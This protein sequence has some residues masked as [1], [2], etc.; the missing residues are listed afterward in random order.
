MEDQ[1]RKRIAQ[2][3]STYKSHARQ[4]GVLACLA[5][6]V[7]LGVTKGLSK[8]GVTMSVPTQVLDCH[9]TGNGAHTHNED[10]YDENGTLVCPLPEKSLHEHTADCYEEHRELICGLDEDESHTHTDDCYLITQELVCGLEEVTEEHVHGPGCFRTVLVD[11]GT[12][13]ETATADGGVVQQAS[14]EDTLAETMPAQEFTGTLKRYDENKREQT[15]LVAQVKAPE[16]TLPAGTTMVVDHLKQ[17]DA[18]VTKTLVEAA[19]NRETL[20]IQ[21]VKQM[22][23]IEITFK[24]ADGQKVQPTGKLEVKL[25]TSLVREAEQPT[26]V[27]IVDLQDPEDYTL[28]PEDGVAEAIDEHDGAQLMK[29]V[30]LV[31]QDENDTSTGNED[32]LWFEADWFAKACPFVIVETEEAE[33]KNEPVEP[34][35][36]ATAE[37]QADEPAEPADEPAEPAQEEPEQELVT[38]E[39]PAQA[40]SHRFLNADKTPL[41]SVAVDAPEG[42]LPA[43]T[44]M[45][46]E[47]VKPSEVQSIVEDAVAEKAEAENATAKEVQAIQAVDITFYD[48]DGEKIEPAEKITVTLSS[49]RI[50]KNAEEQNESLIVHVDDEGKGT[51]VDSLG[52]DELQERDRADETDELVFDADQFSIYAIAYTVDFHYDVDGETY[53]FSITGGDTLSLRELLTALNVVEAGEAEAFVSQV[54]Q[55]EFSNPDLMAVVK[56]DEDTTSGA[57]KAAHELEP[58]YSTTLTED[59]IAELDAKPLYAGDW[60]LVTLKAFDTEESLTITLANGEVFTIKVTDARDPLGLDGR[61]YALIGQAGGNYHALMPSNNGQALN[62]TSFTE[63]T[64]DSSATYAPENS[65]AWKFEYVST[66]D[67]GNNYYRV[68]SGGK[69]LSINGNALAMADA[70]GDG[71]ETDATLIKITRA[72]DGTYTLGNRSGSALVCQGN[73]FNLGDASAAGAK[74]T[75]ALPEDN[76]DASSASHKA[77]LTSASKLQPGQQV[78]IYQRVLQEDHTYNY[79]ALSVDDAGTNAVA[80]KVWPSSD[81]VYWKGDKNLLWTFTEATDEH[82]TPTGY[83]YFENVNKPGVY[84]AAKA[85]G[86]LVQNLADKYQGNKDNVGV[87][88]P[89]RK[90]EQ[91]TSRIANWDYDRSFSSGITLTEAGGAA[92]I[93]SVAL[94]DSQDFYFAVRDPLVQT[95]LTEVDTVDSASKGINITMFDFS[96]DEGG[97]GGARLR[98]MTDVMG[99]PQWAAGV[100]TPGMMS[101]TLTDDNGNFDPTGYPTSAAWSATGTAYWNGYPYQTTFTGGNQSLKNVF[102]PPT[103]AGYNYSSTA[104]NNVNHLFLQDVYDSTGYFR[105]S[106]FENYARLNSDG[107][108]S[109]YEQIGVP[110]TAG[111]DD[112][113]RYYKKRGNFMPYNDLTTNPRS[114]GNITRPED[115]TE[116]DPADPRKYEDLYQ[117]EE[118]RDY[119]FG[120]IMDAKFQQYPGGLND[121]GDPTRYEFNGDDDLWIYI[122]GV[123]VLD[124]GGV[125]DAFAGYIDF[126]TGKVQVYGG[127]T[128]TIKEQFRKAGKFPDGTNWDNNKVD[129]YF[130]GDTFKDYSTHDFKMFYMERGA[131]ASNL[132][133]QFNLMTVTEDHFRVTKEVPTT[134][135]GRTVQQDYADAAFYYTAYKVADNGN[136]TVCTKTEYGSGGTNQ[137]YYDDKDHTPVVW[138]SENIFEVKPGYTA[139]FPVAN[140]SVK[141]RVEEV[142]PEN[143]SAMLDNFKIE[144]SDPEDGQAE[145][146]DVR[147]KTRT[148]KARGEVVYKNHPNDNLVNEL[149]ITKQLRGDMI[150][151]NGGH[152]I[153]SSETGSPYFEYKIY[154]ENRSGELVP[155]SLGE[156]YLIDKD[157]YFVY[158]VAGD[159]LRHRATLEKD[160]GNDG[161]YTYSYNFDVLDEVQ[162]PNGVTASR[163]TTKNPIL[164]EHTSENGSISDI[165]DGD[166]VYVVGLMEGTDFLVFERLDRSI[167]AKD[168]TGDETHYILEGTE[169]TDAYTRNPETNRPE[170]L[171]GTLYDPASEGKVAFSC[172]HEDETA[173]RGTII[174]SKDAKVLVK[175]KTKQGKG[176]I[177]VEKKWLDAEGNNLADHPT[178]I[179]YTVYQFKHVH[180]WGPWTVEKEATETEPGLE[181]QVCQHDSSHRNTRVIA[182][183]PHE[184]EWVKTVHA[185]T[186]DVGGYVEWHCTKDSTHDYIE[187]T[188]E[189]LGH[190]F[191]SEVTQEPTCSTK[192][193]R[194]YTCTRCAHTYTEEIPTTPHTWVDGD[195][196]EEPSASNNYMGKRKRTC[197]VCGKEEIVEFEGDGELYP[198]TNIK[199]TDYV[200][201]Y[202][203]NMGDNDT[204]HIEPGGIFKYGDSYWVIVKSP[205][206]DPNKSQLKDG[207]GGEL[208]DWGCT[209]QLSGTVYTPETFASGSHYHYDPYNPSSCKRDDMKEGDLFK[210]DDGKFYLYKNRY[211]GW[212]VSPEVDASDWY[213][214]FDP[215]NVPVQSASPTTNS[216]ANAPRS[217][218]VKAKN[219][220]FGLLGVGNDDGQGEAQETTQ[221]SITTVMTDLTLSKL[222]EYLGVTA[223]GQTTKGSTLVSYAPVPEGVTTLTLETPRDGAG[224]WSTT[225]PIDIADDQGVEYRYY[226]VEN[227]PQSDEGEFVTTYTGQ[228]DGL[229]NNGVVHITNQLMVKADITL[230][231]VDEQGNAIGGAKFSLQQGSEYLNFEGLTIT[232]IGGGDVAIENVQLLDTESTVPCIV[233]P[234]E[235]VEISGLTNGTYLLR[236]EVAPDGYL[237]TSAAD[238]SFEI[239]NGAVKN[240]EDE[241][242][243]ITFKCVNKAGESLPSTG[244]PGPLLHHLCGVTLITAAGYVGFVSRRK[245]EGRSGT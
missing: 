120:M 239:E 175:N 141:Y 131:G 207:P 10:C 97:P 42:A 75:L 77:S 186:C 104:T 204:K 31:N 195:V 45:K 90:A 65:P 193:V 153:V 24:D 240:H 40:F 190:S 208:Y 167:M 4:A 78:V 92:T 236:E 182:P 194:T 124:I 95:Q 34:Q 234:E 118:P 73:T 15:Y 216:T 30:Y 35:G 217:T 235:G 125:H 152:E 164:T 210:T 29:D 32:T 154:L 196:V 55:V 109:V 62:A 218:R 7:A 187:Y 168:G 59:D 134:A 101:R 98:Y 116:L 198:G 245:R 56:V 177:T 103:N 48:A 226:V 126:S 79:Y 67:A 113:D 122:D 169:V 220:L 172:N 25:T 135:T 112:Y 114:G 224:T 71:S 13:D 16:G 26:L 85:D 44:T 147:T 123:L 184:H 211:T 151:D 99:N 191:T 225:V 21:T 144:N 119:F 80:E 57:L 50:A 23:G 156:Y 162:K 19:V 72:E 70:K 174:M 17:D 136:E 173:G 58:E 87:S 166:T 237:L 178:S 145:G 149:Q 115:G 49:E 100:Y 158:Y 189:P 54:E 202:D 214:L 159:N 89:G 63:L 110:A 228:D 138:K 163:V 51:V 133:M 180:E 121:R 171:V 39:R 36:E 161:E 47:W 105:Y 20:N 28:R 1:I 37:P 88:L 11:D 6:L 232:K 66:D 200:W 91:Y 108:F 82:G 8:Y 128:T 76:S 111:E 14:D 52:A 212:S 107:N 241:D 155:Y 64:S 219:V 102:Y 33:E 140:G 43:G 53:D 183:I 206:N 244:G 181:V 170:H 188:G 205:S 165:R 117:I 142:E 185:A 137:A 143:G 27:Q 83:Y 96:G 3:L 60:A 129:D 221:P 157:G 150:L 242:T 197:S 38:V 238:R 201:P 41:L 81:S 5:L 227:K 203:E 132:E 84:L 146:K 213:L 215:A 127:E 74:I 223:L 222:M 18:D 69:Y 93:S 192:G 243:G 209:M 46:A 148:V 12:P 61:T 106:A 229:A 9:Y 160:K 94:L 231:K 68:S 2:L 233:V 199:I 139:V 130:E 176:E 86:T 22:T 230:K 179:T